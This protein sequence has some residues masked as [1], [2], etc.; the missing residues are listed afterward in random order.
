MARAA[1]SIVAPPPLLSLTEWA[2]HYRYLSSE[3][4]AEPGKFLT[5][6]VPYQRAIMDAIT[7][8]EVEVVVLMMASQTGKTEIMNNAVGY[9]IH[10]DP[11]PMMMVQPTKEMGE[12]WSK[13]RLVPMI[14]DTPALNALINVESRRDGENKILHKKFPGGHLTIAGANSPASL[15]SR[16]IRVLLMDEIDRYPRSAKKEGNPVKLARKRTQTFWNRKII[17]SSSPTIKGE[18]RIE[19]MYE[20]SDKRR[21]WVTCPHCGE[22]Q[23]LVFEHLRWPDGE[24]E[25]AHYVCALNECIISDGDKYFM[26][27]HHEWRAEERFNGIAGFHLPSFYSPYVAFSEFAKKVMESKKDPEDLKV[28]INT[29]LAETYEENLDG[30]GLE[31]DQLTHNMSDYQGAP[32]GVL[33]ITMAVDVQDDRLE[34]EILGWGMDEESWSIRYDAIHGDPGTQEVWRD[35]ED[36]IETTILH[37]RGSEMPIACI[38]VDAGGH[39]AE[40]VYLFCKKKQ[41]QGRRV[42]PVRGYSVSGRPVIGKPSNN[43]SHKVKM[44]YVGTDT[45]K[46]TIF[47]RL[48]IEHPGAGFCHFPADYPESY[49]TGLVSEKLV[50]RYQ[51]GRST[52]QYVKKTASARNEPLDLRVYNMAALKILNP[53]FAKLHLRLEKLTEKKPP[54]DSEDPPHNATQAPPRPAAKRSKRGGGFV[55]RWR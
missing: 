4:S 53:T 31:A 50:K 10:Q 38:T 2:D 26:L 37:A 41:R 43:N 9:Y 39:H 20:H 36:I 48:K 49:F 22:M 11:A 33:V 51:R 25:N 19:E 28:F 17:V 21:L 13:D 12:A 45:A 42:Y 29:E 54:P 1:I 46:D 32:E 14:R 7:D 6:R 15:A 47:S 44:F 52:K 16:P 35:L 3:S 55:Q 23:I 18:S 40:S 5:A 8:P 27:A 24:P 34:F 30:E